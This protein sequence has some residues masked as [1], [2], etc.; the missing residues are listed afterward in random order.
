MKNKSTKLDTGTAAQ[1][2]ANTVLVAGRHRWKEIKLNIKAQRCIK[3]GVERFDT[4]LGWHYEWVEG[5]LNKEQ[6]LRPPCH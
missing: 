6:Y 2:D 1:T 4:K 3:C 5:G